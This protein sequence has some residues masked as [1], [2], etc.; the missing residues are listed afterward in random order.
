MTQ[1]LWVTLVLASLHLSGRFSPHGSTEVA[2]A[3][4]PD[5]SPNRPAPKSN[6]AKFFALSC[7]SRG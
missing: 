6:G 2:V 3:C 1:E 5:V 7:R 4:H